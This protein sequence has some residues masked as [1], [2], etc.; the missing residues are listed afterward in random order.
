MTVAITTTRIQ[1]AGT[2]A[3]TVFPYNFKVWA[4]TELVVIVTDANGVETVKT[5][6]VD[7]SVSGVGNDTGG[8]VTFVTAPAATEKVTIMRALPQKQET[9]YVENDPFP[10]MATENALDKLTMMVQELQEQAKRAPLLRRSSAYADLGL[11]DPEVTDRFL[12]WK[13]DL[14]GLENVNLSAIADLVTQDMDVAGFVKNLADG[15]FVGGN[16]PCD[17]NPTTPGFVKNTAGGGLTGGSILTAADLPVDFWV[18]VDESATDQADDQ[19]ANSV[20]HIAAQFAGANVGLLF[21][22]G[23]TFTF[24]QSYTIPQ[25]LQLAV[26]P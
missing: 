17:T 25:N 3:Q 2:G 10:A 5:L 22:R 7:Y 14:S 24:A 4:E 9:D 18:I 16:Y 13:S 20:A 11:P 26:Q 23:Q 21:K 6:N 15:T 1:Y 8:N 12:R 19:Q